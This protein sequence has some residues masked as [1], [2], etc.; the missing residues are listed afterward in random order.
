V[1]LT[2]FRYDI[3]KILSI[4]DLFVVSSLSEGLPTSLLEAMSAGIPPIVTDIGLPIINKI[5]GL[6]IK[7]QNSKIIAESIEFLIQNPQMTENISKEAR[8]FIKKNYSID[9]TVNL[10][11]E[12]F[13]S[14]LG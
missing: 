14:L 7:P 9:K 1:L 3:P 8:R 5:N 6:V 4:S 11:L 13:K 10:H 12:V 2:G